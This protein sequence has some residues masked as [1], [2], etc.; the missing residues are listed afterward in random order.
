MLRRWWGSESTEV[1]RAAG[2]FLRAISPLSLA[3]DDSEK[4]PRPETKTRAALTEPR[5]RTVLGLLR[6]ARRSRRSETAAWRL[7]FELRSPGGNPWIGLHW[8]RGYWIIRRSRDRYVKRCVCELRPAI[9]SEAQS[10]RETESLSFK[11]LN[12]CSLTG[13]QKCVPFERSECTSA[14]HHFCRVPIYIYT[15]SSANP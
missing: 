10:N 14:V 4:D 15:A 7:T 9:V 11:L 6:N 12:S 13:E 3:K 2:P 8:W 5:T 1:S